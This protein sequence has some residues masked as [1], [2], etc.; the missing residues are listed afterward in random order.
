MLAT[1]FGVLFLSF[2]GAVDL[3][4]GCTL[5]SLEVI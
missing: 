1:A 2:S 4:F 3:N 5:E